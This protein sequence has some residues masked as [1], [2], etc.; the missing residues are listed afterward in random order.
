MRQRTILVLL[1]RAWP[2]DNAQVVNTSAAPMEDA[3]TLLERAKERA[4][5]LKLPYAGALLPS[6]AHQLLQSAGDARI[7]DVRSRAEW[8]WVGRIPDAVMIEWNS[9]PSGERNPAFLDELKARMPKTTAPALF[10]CRSGARSHHAAAAAAQ[11]GYTNAINVLEGFEGDKDA[12]G[13]RNSVGGW[14]A[15][16]LPWEQS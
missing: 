6:E 8:D 10:I 4:A 9:W 15:A 7:V 16:G 2:G 12:Q 1:Q 3:K 14:R 5:K 13:H 11:A